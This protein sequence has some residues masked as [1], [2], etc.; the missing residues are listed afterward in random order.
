M[1]HLYVCSAPIPDNSGTLSRHLIGIL[2]LTD[3]N[4]YEFKY[5]LDDSPLCTNLMLPIFPDKDKTYDDT[6]TRVLLDDYL[7]SET[8]TT[9]MQNILNKSEM[10][11]Y[12]EW[13]WL[14]TFESDDPDSETCLYEM[15][16]DNIIRHDHPIALEKDAISSDDEPDTDPVSNDIDYTDEN[17]YDNIIAYEKADLTDV[18][19]IDDIYD[20]DI[21]DPI[22]NPSDLSDETDF[23]PF[24]EL[25]DE[26][27]DM[28]DKI[29]NTSA[30]TENTTEDIT[31]PV[32]TPIIP[33][34]HSAPAEPVP[35]EII[36]PPQ[37]KEHK[38]PQLTSTKHSHKTVT[39]TTTHKIRK[40]PIPKGDFIEAPPESPANLIEQ[41]L[42]EN[43]KQ[44]QERL[45]AQLNNTI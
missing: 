23:D 25:S 43:Q 32:I 3:Q 30:E 5:A 36:S 19:E 16:P 28:I 42:R 38:Y 39:I 17:S 35:E 27:F 31:K 14:R 10:K 41:R 20:F 8:D 33:P 26:D 2:T 12:N 29:I 13:E 40:N 24:S 22:D 11:E 7:P 15:L 37:V 45:Q 44:R 34:I 21:D 9:F 6:E 18:D 4:T 1:K